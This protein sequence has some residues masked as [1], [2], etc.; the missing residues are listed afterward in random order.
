M[1][2]IARRRRTWSTALEE[3]VED[4]TTAVQDQSYGPEPNNDFG[5]ESEA[6]PED[7]FGADGALEDEE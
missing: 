6:S 1:V 2:P 3:E 4:L 7:D 5:Y